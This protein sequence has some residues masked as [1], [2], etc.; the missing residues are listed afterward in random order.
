MRLKFFGTKAF[1]TSEE[2]NLKRFFNK[3]PENEFWRFFVERTRYDFRQELYR[4]LYSK[5]NNVSEEEAK[6][7][8]VS[9]IEEMVKDVTVGQVYELAKQLDDQESLHGLDNLLHAR[10]RQEERIVALFNKHQ[11]WLGF[12]DNEPGYLLNVTK[13][14]CFAIEHLL[15]GKPLT[16]D[17]IKELHKTCTQGVQKMLKQTPGEFRSGGASWQMNSKDGCDSLEGL[18]ET[19]DYLKSVE[20]KMG[21]SGLDITIETKDGKEC[22]SKFLTE[23]T[24]SL[25]SKIW[26]N[27]NN[28]AVI[29][30]NSR[31]KEVDSSQFLH[32]VCSD[33]I[34][35]LEKA[36]DNAI[37]KEEKLTA[38][39]TYLKHTVLHHPFQDGVGRTYSMVLFQYLLM[40]ENLSPVLILNS[41]VIPGVSVK[42]LVNEYLRA[43]KEM[44][45]ILDNPQYIASDEMVTPNVDTTTLLSKSNT[46]ER[47]TFT[48]ALTLFQK[49]KGSFLEWAKIQEN[50]DSEVKQSQIEI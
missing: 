4:K 50:K 24:H 49:I 25:A 41:N 2:N 44:E 3:F 15:S 48:S 43:E 33:H 14:L 18:I 9:L 32:E 46:E 13:G 16:L 19:I 1:G 12:E 34:Q 35:Q 7:V 17:F 8:P 39:F 37:T 40:R 47:D 31:E 36:L 23:D 42:E 30:Y 28:G 21:T 38:L 22:I 5:L 6:K 45:K 20:A 27:L 29:Y 10:D 11:G 26:T